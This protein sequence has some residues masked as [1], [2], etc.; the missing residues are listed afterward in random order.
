MYVYNADKE[1]IVYCSWGPMKE[2]EESQCEIK[3]PKMRLART[4]SVLQ[5]F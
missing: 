4:A 5:S 3:N 1:I 2:F